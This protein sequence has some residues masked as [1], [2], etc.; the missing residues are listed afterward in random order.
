M[1]SLT[2]LVTRAQNG[3]LDA[4]GTI[5]RRFQDMAVG[6]AYTVL[7][8]FHLAEDAAQE[9]FIGAYLDLPKLRNPQAFQGW[10]RKTVFKHCDRLTRGKRIQTVPLEV[11]F[12][13][14]SRQKGPDTLAEEAEMK[15]RVMAAL[16]KLPEAERAVTAL[17]YINGYS[18][19][20]IGAFLE[21]PVTTVKNRLRAARNHL[22]ERMADMVRENLSEQRPSKD[23]VFLERV[24]ADLAGLSHRKIQVVFHRA[25]LSLRELAIAFKDADEQLRSKVLYANIHERLRE[26]IEEEL[27]HMGPIRES[28]V[29]SVR[30]RILE[31]VDR[32]EK[33]K[34]DPPFAPDAAYQSKQGYLIDTLRA[35]LVIEL[36]YDRISEVI[37]RLAECA[38][39]LGIVFSFKDLILVAKDSVLR[40]YL[41]LIGHGYP[42]ARVSDM[43]ETLTQTMMRHHEA[44]YRMVLEA[45]VGIQQGRRVRV[46]EQCLR[47]LHVPG[48]PERGEYLEASAK[49][50]SARLGETPLCQLSLDDIAEILTDISVIART[51]GAASLDQITESVQD[52]LLAQGLELAIRGEEQEV[53]E[54]V[55]ARRIQ[56]LLQRHETQYEMVT[57]G[58][59]AIQNAEHPR[60]IEQ[61]MKSY[62]E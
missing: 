8:D 44:R 58:M 21:V 4:Y 10:F 60:V 19:D 57:A 22:R 15:D 39:Q 49:D 2:T 55:L 31:T 16:R 38:R 53:I 36:G 14:S 26:M 34:R 59:L 47:T 6:Y 1:D 3:E 30:A 52:E 35:S 5:V 42:P 24:M 40:L 18:Q 17:F 43:G 41:Q 11:A 51:E 27:V 45:V 12:G 9:A 54:T 7:G 28:E 37:V 48:R 32:L 46:V 25:E 20:E 29:E 33:G 13:V 50:I 61:K 56:T 23:E 62:Y